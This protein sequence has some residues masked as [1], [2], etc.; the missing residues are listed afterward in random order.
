MFFLTLLSY[1][2]RLSEI[3]FSATSR[4]AFQFWDSF[5]YFTH[6]IIEAFRW[7]LNLLSLYFISNNSS[8]FCFNVAISYVMYSLNSLDSFVHFWLFLVK[9]GIILKNIISQFLSDT[10]VKSEVDTDFFPFFGNLSIRNLIHLSS[11]SSFALDHCNLMNVF[12]S[13]GLFKN[14][15]I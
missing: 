14:V 6:S 7:V 13:L 15:F 10:L 3:T 9:I 8:W 4:G 5:L 1:F 12:F 11:I 2:F